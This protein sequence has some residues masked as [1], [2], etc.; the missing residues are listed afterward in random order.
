[1]FPL[2]YQDEYLIDI[3]PD[4]ATETWARLAAGLTGGVIASNDVVD[5]STYLIPEEVKAERERVYANPDT[6]QTRLQQV[7]DNVGDGNV[8]EIIKL[9]LTAK[10]TEEDYQTLEARFSNAA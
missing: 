6:L 8:A 7:D 3:T 4:A 1:M 9:C 5:Q 2:N 10:G